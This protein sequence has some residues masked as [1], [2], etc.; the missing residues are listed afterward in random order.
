MCAQAKEMPEEEWVDM[1]EKVDEI[2]SRVGD[3]VKRDRQRVI[4]VRSIWGMIMF[5]CGLTVWYAADALSTPKQNSK[6]IN[7]NAVAIGQ[8]ESVVKANMKDDVDH[9]DDQKVHMDYQKK[10]ETFVPR[11]EMM[12]MMQS[13][14]EQDALRMKTIT[15]R[16]TKMEQELVDSRKLSEKILEKVSGL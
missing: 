9:H 5:V 7:S 10:V 1:K 15:E 13:D 6:A 2:D 16:I 11:T 12:F 4:F 3:I 8:L 14:H